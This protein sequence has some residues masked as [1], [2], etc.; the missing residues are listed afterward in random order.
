MRLSKPVAALYFA[1]IRGGL[2]P[3]NLPVPFTTR[4]VL[5]VRQLRAFLGLVVGSFLASCSDGTGPGG[6]PLD[7]SDASTRA[8]AVGQHVILDPAQAGACVRLPAA[9]S[10]GAEHLYIALA[11]AGQET[12]QGVS[13]PYIVSGTSPATAS[14]STIP[15]HAAGP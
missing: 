8:L 12:Q 6:S 4:S 1:S 14:V 10:S 9:G 13:A 3:L 5:A 7:C 2:L 15:Q 11:T